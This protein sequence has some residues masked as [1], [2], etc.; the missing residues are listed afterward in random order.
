M[1]KKPYDIDEQC[2][3]E[4]AGKDRIQILNE[5]IPITKNFNSKTKNYVGKSKYNQEKNES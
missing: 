2:L 5:T 1:S 4:S 3:N